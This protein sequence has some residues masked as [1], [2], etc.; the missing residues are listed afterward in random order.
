MDGAANRCRPA[1]KR[2]PFPLRRARCGA[3]ALHCKRA[4]PKPDAALCHARRLRARRIEISRNPPDSGERVAPEK[5][6]RGGRQ[7]TNKALPFGKRARKGVSKMETCV[8]CRRKVERAENW[9]KCH[10]WG[11]FAIFHW[12]CFGEYLRSESEQQVENAV[13][14]ASRNS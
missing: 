14:Q 4:S 2:L 10:L 13:W 9:I 11:G 1:Q 7:T 8:M 3:P 12:R 6:A 5:V